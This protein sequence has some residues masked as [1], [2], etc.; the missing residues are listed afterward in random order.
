MFFHH[1]K[2]VEPTLDLHIYT[3]IPCWQLASLKSHHNH[4]Q[5]V[6]LLNQFLV[7]LNQN[8][9]LEQKILHILRFTF[10]T[11]NMN[12]INPVF[13]NQ[14]EVIQIFNPQSIKTLKINDDCSNNK[15][16][17][18]FNLWTH[19]PKHLMNQESHMWKLNCVL[20]PPS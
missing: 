3:L 18:N 19:N 13:Y 15:I 17:F 10:K 2:K 14:N 7:F 20:A 5:I 6:S 4:F 8:T 16:M 1:W 9:I 11:S 12:I